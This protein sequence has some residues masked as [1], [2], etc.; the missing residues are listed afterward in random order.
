MILRI[1]KA[2]PAQIALAWV[3]AQKPFIVPIVGVNKSEYLRENLGAL[4]L[5]FSNEELKEIENRL[6]AITIVGVCDTFNHDILAQKGSN[7]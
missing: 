1:L 2:T 6:E 4:E 5:S 7:E 3:N